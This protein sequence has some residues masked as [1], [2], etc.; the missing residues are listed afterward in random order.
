M[1]AVGASPAG[2]SSG[3]R[4][5][6]V[7]PVNFAAE[8]LAGHAARPADSSLHI[9]HLDA[10]SCGIPPRTLSVLL[11]G[12]DQSRCRAGATRLDR[13]LPYPAWR[14]LVAAAGPPASLVLAMLPLEGK[15]GAL[16]LPSGARR[17]LRDIDIALHP[18]RA[19]GGQAECKE[20]EVLA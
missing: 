16:R 5:V 15:G 19:K 9:L 8:A 13:E 12:I 7:L 6:A 11:D 18:L 14:R 10:S 17:R 2:L 20:D 3:G 4:S 1:Q